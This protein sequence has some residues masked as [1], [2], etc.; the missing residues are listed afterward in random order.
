MTIYPL[1]F[2]RRADEKWAR[3]QVLRA[4][5]AKRC[6]LSRVGREGLAPDREIFTEFGC[7]T[8]PDFGTARGARIVDPSKDWE[9][10]RRM[11]F[12]HDA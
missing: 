6:L 11:L 8:R 7:G 3:A 12:H 9:P 1:E 2:Q 4:S 5:G 10:S